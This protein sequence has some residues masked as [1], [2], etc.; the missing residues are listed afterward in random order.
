MSK[1][2]SV[3]VPVYNVE[4]YLQRCVDSL[5]QQSHE[6]LEIILVDDGSK[7]QSG[8]ICDAYA[9]Q[10]ARVKVIH[11]QNAGQSVARNQG[12]KIAT[13]DYIC[14]ADSDDYVHP[15]YIKR[16]YQMLVGED[17][18]IAMCGFDYFKGEYYEGSQTEV[19]ASRKTYTNQEMIRNM[20]TVQDELYV[21]VWGKLYKR[22]IVEGIAFPEGR[23]CEDL[24][25]LYRYYDRAAKTVHSEDV[26]YY[27]YRNNVNSS[28]YQINLKFYEDVFLALEE[29]AGYLHDQGYNELEQYAKKTQM[30]WQ[31]DLYTKIRK[32]DLVQAKKCLKK[33][34]KL[35]R[36]T[37]GI[38]KEKFYTFFY[39]VPNIYIKYK[40]K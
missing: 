18:D 29:E 17:A 20:H 8:E 39:Y 1:K 25:V 23:I 5:L 26:L 32:A 4:K 30:Y 24:A 27:Y 6:D 36:E 13:G 14:Y 33:Y 15:D 3:I 11:Q 40:R 35:Y 34:R 2:V 37:K 16:M 7:D 10:D 12:L 22:E 21:V 31:F 9:Q 28:T 19:S 38:Q